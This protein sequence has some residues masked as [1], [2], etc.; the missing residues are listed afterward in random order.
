MVGT[1]QVIGTHLEGVV[2]PI[3]FDTESFYSSV[4]AAFASAFK[5]QLAE[6]TAG[7]SS[8]NGAT[9]AG[10]SAISS[11]ANGA[12]ATNLPVRRCDLTGRFICGWR[13]GGWRGGI[14]VGGVASQFAN[15]SAN[16]LSDDIQLLFGGA[17][18]MKVTWL[19]AIKEEAARE[20]L[21][22]EAERRPDGRDP[23]LLP[24]IR[25]LG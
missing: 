18:A 12:A 19:V 1:A 22:H 2:L 11:S 15:L 5:V 7:T 9:A 14:A 17:N 4:L 8:A 20:G 24:R 21:A 16:E 6:R 3:G 23:G 10:T 25:R 13:G